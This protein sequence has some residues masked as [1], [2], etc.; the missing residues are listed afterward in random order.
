MPPVAGH[1]A[2]D[3]RSYRS[4]RDRQACPTEPPPP[5]ACG[6]QG[7]CDGE[8]ATPLP[9]VLVDPP[10]GALY[11]AYRQP[12]FGET[13]FSES[14]PGNS[15]RAGG[16]RPTCRQPQRRRLAESTLA[17][18]NEQWPNGRVHAAMLLAVSPNTGILSASGSREEGAV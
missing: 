9:V 4:E 2:V 6:N 14:L 15:S 18:V 10:G 3:H 1:N 7:L 17:V 11:V 8:V 5:T 13:D 16:W 12:E